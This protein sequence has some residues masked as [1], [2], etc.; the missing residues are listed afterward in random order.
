MNDDGN[1]GSPWAQALRQIS[2]ITDGVGMMASVTG[3][4]SAAVCSGALSAALR[5]AA[6]AVEGQSGKR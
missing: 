1:R 6:D 3:R 2:W 5:I 4:E